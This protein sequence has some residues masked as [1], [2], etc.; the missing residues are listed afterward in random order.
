[1]SE[2]VEAHMRERRYGEAS[3]CFHN[4]NRR[5]QERRESA[6]Q[7][8]REVL[9]CAEAS[10]RSGRTLPEIMEAARVEARK[11]GLLRDKC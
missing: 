5:D 2:L 11:R 3:E 7:Q 1:M 4:L 6:I 8:L 10:D 9:D